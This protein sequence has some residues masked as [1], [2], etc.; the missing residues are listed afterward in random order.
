MKKRFTFLAALFIAASIFGQSPEKTSILGGN[1]Q[2]MALAPAVPEQISYQAVVRDDN[3]A[4]VANQ[5]VGMRISVLQNTVAGTAVYVETQTPTTNASGLLSIYI[6]AGTVGSGVFSDIVWST[7]PYFIKTEIDPAGGTTYGI[8]GTTQLAS[9]P[10]ALYAKTA[11]N[12][13]LKE[14]TANKSTDVATD[15]AS[16]VKFPSVKSVKTYADIVQADVAASKTASTTSDATL[17][18]YIDALEARISAI[19]LSLAT[20]PGAPTGVTVAAGNTQVTV[21]FT[22][23]SSDGGSAITSYTATSSPEN[24]TATL[25]QAESGAITVTGLT[26]GTVYTFTVTATNTKGSSAAS[27]VSTSVTPQQGAPDAPTG[28]SAIAGNTQATVSFTAPSNDGGSVITSYTATSNPGN[29]TGTLSQAGGGTITLNGLTNGTIYT[30]TVTATNS[31]G[32]S[33]ASTEGHMTYTILDDYTNRKPTGTTYVALRNYSEYI[34]A[35]SIDASPFVITKLTSFAEGIL[36]Y[37]STELNSQ[38]NENTFRLTSTAGNFD[39]ISFNLIDLEDFIDYGERTA[40]TI[41][42]IT[43]TSS[44]GNTVS[45]QSSVYIYDYGEYEYEYEYDFDNTG[46]KEL[47]WSNV[48]WVDIKTQYTKAKTKDYVLTNN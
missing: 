47:N 40:S 15:A 26:N 42:K 3:N 29:I 2:K 35:G 38:A 24:I 18:G 7:G 31:F 23:P 20:V 44:S 16:D 22:V 46:V 4:I 17:R 34:D 41:P 1:N 19:E 30:F 25:S 5:V 11:G 8:I 48:E 43:L 39:F 10:Y 45:Y 13:V 28:V 6:G 14:N 32:T 37:G 36:F 27:G 9:V 21:S 33:T 12:D